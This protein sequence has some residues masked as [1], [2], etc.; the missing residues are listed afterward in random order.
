MSNE[1]MKLIMFGAVILYGNGP[2]D[3]SSCFLGCKLTAIMPCSSKSILR[4]FVIIFNA[5]LLAL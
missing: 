5:A 1:E 3:L 4:H 2:S